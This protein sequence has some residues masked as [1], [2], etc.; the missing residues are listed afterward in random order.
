MPGG[1]DSWPEAMTDRTWLVRRFLDG[2]AEA[3]AGRSGRE[4]SGLERGFLS[5]PF[6]LSGLS[7]FAGLVFVVAFPKLLFEFFGNQIDGGVE[8]AFGV[9]GIEIGSWHGQSHGAGELFFRSAFAVQ[10]ESD[11]D[12]NGAMIEVIELFDPRH[13][14]IFDGFGE[15]QVM[16][17]QNQFHSWSLRWFEMKIQSK[18]RVWRC[19]ML[20]GAFIYS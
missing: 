4:G 12:I 5:S 2:V 16:G 3:C 14:M 10:F 17:R 15:C 8:I 18:V 19:H 11:T 13:E 1:I 9:F 7:M 20:S 6:A